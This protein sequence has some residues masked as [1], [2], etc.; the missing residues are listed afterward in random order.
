MASVRFIKTTKEKHVNRATYDQNALYFCE[1]TGEL[2]KGNRVYTDGMRM[3]QTFEDLPDF[4]QA[5]D[6]IMYYIIET[7]NGYVLNPT[8]NGWVQT[9]YA[10]ATN[11]DD[12]PEGEEHNVVATVAIVQD[13]EQE[14]KTYV[15]EQVITGGTGILDGGEI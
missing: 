10:P 15:D 4:N 12:V 14:M 5:A 2:F 6:G 8:R 11:I 9:I 1:D 3:L 13:L 7:R